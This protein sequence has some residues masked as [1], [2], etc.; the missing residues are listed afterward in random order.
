MDRSRA[1]QVATE[2]Q[3]CAGH[4][5]ELAMSVQGGRGAAGDARLRAQTDTT[6]GL[7]QADPRATPAPSGRGGD[8]AAE[9]VAEHV[10]RGSHLRPESPVRA[11]IP[12]PRVLG[13]E[14]PAEVGRRDA[15]APRTMPKWL[16]DRAGRPALP[17]RGQGARHRHDTK[18][19]PLPLVRERHAPPRSRAV[20]VLR[21]WQR[22]G[23]AVARRPR[24]YWQTSLALN[25]IFSPVF[26]V[27]LT[28]Q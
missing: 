18:L 7:S 11:G 28:A 5:N 2:A 26:A 8:A 10:A 15:H 3:K 17:R 23:A 1:P 16:N 22:G 12:G 21:W 27:P 13:A 6:K 4:A 9:P 20:D 19:D 25:P 24:H 14:F